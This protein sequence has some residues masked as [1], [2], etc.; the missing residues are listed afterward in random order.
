MHLNV[1]TLISLVALAK[2]ATAEAIGPFYIRSG[3]KAVTLFV[4]EIPGQ[5]SPVL[6][7]KENVLLRTNKW[8]YDNDTGYITD[9]NTRLLLAIILAGNGLDIEGE[10]PTLDTQRWDWDEGTGQIKSRFD[11]RCISAPNGG[12]YARLRTC[13]SGKIGKDQQWLPYSP[14]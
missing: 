14:S 5:G 2:F 12:R 13:D 9:S 3:A 10:V 1:P 6:V 8:S 11:G 7:G 4:A